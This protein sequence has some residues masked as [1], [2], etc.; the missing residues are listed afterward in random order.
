MDGSGSDIDVRTE[1]RRKTQNECRRSERCQGPAITIMVVLVD[2]V[3]V[4]QPLIGFVEQIERKA[5][6]RNRV[7]KCRQDTAA[8]IAE[9]P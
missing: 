9:R 2:G 5:N 8:M 7:D 1:C 4:H 6:Q 3:R